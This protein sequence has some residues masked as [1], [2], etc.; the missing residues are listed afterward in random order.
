[1]WKE[2]K[3]F[4]MKGNVMD[5]AVGIM[6]G[7]AF[8]SIIRSLVSDVVM[9]PIGLVLGEVDISDFFI[10]LKHG[11]EPGPYTTLSQAQGAGA[12]TI[13]YGLFMNA[14]TSFLIIAMTMFLL[15]DSLKKLK[16]REEVAEVKPAA[17]EC[18]YCASSISLKATRCPNCTSELAVS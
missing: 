18:P 13:N 8:N 11:V 3:E 7:T 5:M 2:F 15:V 14:F 1:M 4:A 16:R 9:P 17:R 12:V 10:V 6:I